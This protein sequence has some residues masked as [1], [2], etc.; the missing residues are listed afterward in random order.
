[1]HSIIGSCRFYQHDRAFKV[2]KHAYA[3]LETFVNADLF[4]TTITFLYESLFLA[5]AD[6]TK[7]QDH[8]VHS[9]QATIVRVLKNTLNIH[10]NTISNVMSENSYVEQILRVGLGT[11]ATCHHT[12]FSLSTLLCETMRHQQVLHHME[13]VY[14]H[15]YAQK[16]VQEGVDGSMMYSHALQFILKIFKQPRSVTDYDILAHCI[17][18]M[19]VI[20]QHVGTNM[21]IEDFQICV[22][23]LL[24]RLKVQLGVSSWELVCAMCCRMVSRVVSVGS[25]DRKCVLLEAIVHAS[26][27]V[28]DEYFV[29][30]LNDLRNIYGYLSM[31]DTS[32]T[33]G[34]VR[35]V[36]GLLKVPFSRPDHFTPEMTIEYVDST[37]ISLLFS[38]IMHSYIETKKLGCLRYNCQMVVLSQKI[39]HAFLPPP[40][41]CDQIRAHSILSQ[42]PT[43]EPATRYT[44]MR[45]RC[46]DEPVVGTQARR[47]QNL[48]DLTYYSLCVY[49]AGGRRQLKRRT[50][51][52]APVHL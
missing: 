46:T 15:K 34:V 22:R 35:D 43:G 25:F 30:L 10:A 12:H 14:L 37:C 42:N 19:D 50:L 45:T 16:F 31:L 5:L 17:G 51:T 21:M 7:N 44:V 39:L 48:H 9:L 2:R 6:H 23:V 27:N 3:L 41:Y 38:K 32:C 47:R 13:C 33:V 4:E 24:S 36:V 18:I 8:N 1:V 11:E 52:H 20:S 28:S 26:K 29:V 49:T 40:C